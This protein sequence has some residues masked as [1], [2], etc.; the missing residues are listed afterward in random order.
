MSHSKCID[1][2]FGEL[3]DEL[4]PN[5]TDNSYYG[6]SVEVNKEILDK[7][8]SIPLVNPIRAEELRKILERANR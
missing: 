5:T 7:F 8:N 3:I 6:K 2:I 1:E 4:F